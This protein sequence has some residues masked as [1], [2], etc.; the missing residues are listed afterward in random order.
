MKTITA[1]LALML[2]LAS[3]AVDCGDDDSDGTPTASTTPA[4]TA[5]AS[6]ST[7]PPLEDEVG[8]A[9]LNYWDVY[10]DAV[11]NLDESA[12][13][14]VMMGPLLQR[15]LE[16]IAN[17]RQQN[18]AAKIDVEHNFAVLDVDSA[19]GT[20]VVRDAYANRSAFVDANTK[21][22]IGQPADGEIITDTYT[23]RLVDGIWKVEDSVRDTQ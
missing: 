10:S 2:L 8:T 16:E 9:Y 19:V 23:L 17:L 14:Q 20:A 12:L 7:T 3:F 5:T 4:T 1:T 11:F 21:E 18:R 15:T 6:G 22:L 13:E